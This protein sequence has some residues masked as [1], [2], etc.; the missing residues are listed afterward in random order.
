MKLTPRQIQ[1]MRCPPDK[2]KIDLFDTHTPGLMVELRKSG[3]ATFY[4]RY[5][6]PNGRRRHLR[7]GD[8]DAMNLTDAR[9]A[10]KRLNG[11]IANGEDPR[12]EQISRRQTPT[13]E[14][15]VRERYLPY[16][17]SYK[18]SWQTDECLLRNHILPVIG[19]KSMGSVT[20]G[21]A[22][23]LI[24]KHRQNHR[25]SS[26]NRVLILLRYLY[27]LALKWEIPGVSQNPTA[28]IPL[29]IENNKRERYL[30]PEETQRLLREIRR[31]QN[32]L[33][34]EIIP[35][36]ILTGARRSEVLKAR[37]EDL[38]LDR[39]MWRIPRPK[40][41]ERR[42]VPISETLAARLKVLPSCGT[43]PWLFPNPRTGKPFDSIY[44]AWNAARRRAG[45]AEVRLH[46]LRHSFASLLINN[47]H[48]LYEVQKLLGHTQITTTQ[49]YAHLAQETLLEAMNHVGEMLQ[50]TEADV[51]RST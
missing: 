2:A 26:T 47:G 42:F 10:V 48:S 45:L 32:P 46:D 11:R 3:K 22:L 50:G 21:E 30:T 23:E 1:Q 19:H 29:Y 6:D 17:Q 16:A 38:D 14:A 20:K 33:L 41:G 44:T 40:G 35:M 8:V 18:R 13:L 12:Q 39:H 7:L 25:P 43:S 36:L 51:V 5:Q 24:Q 15:F 9:R 31:S 34:Q 49:R 37:W 27:N 4:L 28:S